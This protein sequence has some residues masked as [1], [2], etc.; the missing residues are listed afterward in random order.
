MCECGLFITIAKMPL[1]TSTS[2][3]QLW[4]KVIG[5]VVAA[6]TV[7]VSNVDG[8]GF[9]RCPNYPSMPRFNISRVNFVILSLA[10]C[11]YVCRHL[12]FR[13]VNA[14]RGFNLF[15]LSL[16]DTSFIYQYLFCQNNHAKII[17]IVKCYNPK[18]YAHRQVDEIGFCSL[19][20]LSA[21]W[22][23]YVIHAN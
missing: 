12:V 14:L 9:G 11:E 3:M 15:S 4:A 21:L 7:A 16:S 18:R 6:L 17:D 1:Q 8:S 23:F 10:S 22:G 19:A 13:E 2:R 5:T 20:A